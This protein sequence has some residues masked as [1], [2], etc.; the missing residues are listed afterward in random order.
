MLRPPDLVAT[1]LCDDLCLTLSII[2]L[3]INTF[4]EICKRKKLKHIITIIKVGVKA[5]GYLD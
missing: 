4:W 5:K 2:F 1:E 3:L